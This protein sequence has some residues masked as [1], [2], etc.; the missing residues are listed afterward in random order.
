MLPEL[1]TEQEDSTGALMRLRV[2]AE[3]DPSVIAQVLGRFQILNVIP[4]RVLADVGATGTLEIALD[5]FG[6][7][8]RRLTLIAAKLRQSPCVFNA[9]WHYLV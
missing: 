7:S 4:R 6:L 8:E 9:R 2:T 5:I 3:A 1:T